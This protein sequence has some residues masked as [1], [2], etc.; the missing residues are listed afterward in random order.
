MRTV[1][2]IKGDIE[3]FSIVGPQHK[4]DMVWLEWF[5]AVAGTIEPDRLDAICQAEREQRAVVLPCKVGD[6][7]YEITSIFDGQKVHR[8]I[9]ERAITGLGGNQLNPIWMVSK[10]PYEI[11]FHPSQFGKTVFLTPEAAQAALDG[12]RP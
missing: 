6:T 2:E 7:V 11:R 3:Y 5:R 8:E 12:G 4:L 9:K 1:E 10:E